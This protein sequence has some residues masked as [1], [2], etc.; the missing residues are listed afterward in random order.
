MVGVRCSAALID[1]HIYVGLHLLLFLILLL[2]KNETFQ[3]KKSQEQECFTNLWLHGSDSAHTTL[4]T[5]H[6][7]AYEGP[8]HHSEKSNY[9]PAGAISAQHLVCSVKN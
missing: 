4:L 5:L 3:G 8:V 9:L 6:F 2:R 1:Q 7:A